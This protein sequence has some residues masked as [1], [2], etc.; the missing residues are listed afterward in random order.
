[1]AAVLLFDVMG[2]LVRD[3]FFEELPAFFGLDMERFVQEKHP[4]AWIEFEQGRLDARGYATRMFRDRRA[5]DMDA[6][7]RHVRHGYAYLDGIE[8]LLGDLAARGVEMHALSNYPVWY[9]MIDEKLGLGRFVQWSFVS[10]LTGHRKPD[11]E[12]YT[13]AL[14]V[15]GRRPGECLF[16]DDRPGNCEGAAAVGIPSLLFTDAARLRRELEQRGVL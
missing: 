15:L 16:V 8:A 2:T 11:P 9:R 7:E 13:H 6:L 1:M 5:V 12:A 14:D 10:C 4:T 3:P